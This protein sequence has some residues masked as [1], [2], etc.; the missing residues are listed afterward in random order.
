[1]NKSNV[2]GTRPINGITSLVSKQEREQIETN[3]NNIATNTA[4]IATNATDISGKQDT[5]TSA[6]AITL[7]SINFPV[8]DTVGNIRLPG[9]AILIQVTVHTIGMLRVTRVKLWVGILHLNDYSS[10]VTFYQINFYT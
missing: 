2:A 7:R 8:V 10:L 9:N 5:L 4:D 3:K 1:M 6:S